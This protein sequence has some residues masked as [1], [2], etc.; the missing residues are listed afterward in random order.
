MPCFA[1]GKKNLIS[2]KKTK[3]DIVTVYIDPAPLR[4]KLIATPG[5]KRNTKMARRYF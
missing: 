2:D 4:N 3:D 5:T 1:V